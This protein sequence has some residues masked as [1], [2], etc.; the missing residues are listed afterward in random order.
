SP[1]VLLCFRATCRRAHSAVDQYIQRN[2]NICRFLSRYFADPLGFRQ[3]QAETGTLIS[4]SSALQFFDRTFYPDSDLDLYV[5]MVYRIEV[6]NYLMHC[7]YVYTPSARQN[8]DFHEAVWE[9]RIVNVSMNYCAPGVAGVFNFIKSVTNVAS[10]QRWLKVQIIVSPLCPLE[11]VL[12]FHSTCVMN[13]ISYAAAYCFYPKATLEKRTSLIC[14]PRSRNRQQAVDKYGQRGWHM[15]DLAREGVDV[16]VP[17]KDFY[18][19]FQ[20]QIP[21]PTRW[22]GD[23]H[24]WTI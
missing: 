6:G 15:L 2:W 7:G 21:S 12:R 1:S 24:C 9:S 8:A 17:V 3:L 14:Q 20:K 23:K 11:S 13:V 16:D 5:P 19:S 22:V 18:I 4:G 10:G